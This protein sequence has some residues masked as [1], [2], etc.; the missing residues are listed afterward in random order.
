MAN[1]ELVHVKIEKHLIE[2]WISGM[3][4]SLVSL[5]IDPLETSFGNAGTLEITLRNLCPKLRSLDIKMDYV[6]DL[7]YD[8]DG[9]RFDWKALTSL[10]IVAKQCIMELKKINKVLEELHLEIPMMKGLN[11]G[12]TKLPSILHV[13]LLRRFRVLCKDRREDL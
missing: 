8:M 7:D 4:N 1:L 3:K 11:L 5:R 6:P 10:K 9:L 12:L 2:K 13:S